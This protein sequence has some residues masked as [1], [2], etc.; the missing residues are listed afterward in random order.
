MSKNPEQKAS[1]ADSSNRQHAKLRV[2]DLNKC[3][4]HCCYD[5]VYMKDGEETKIRGLVESAPDF[6]SSL[7][8]DF[9]VDGFWDGEYSGRKTATRPH[10]FER[11]DIPEHFTRTRCVF[12]SADHKCMLQVLAV[13][14][15]LHKWLYKPQSCWLFPLRII[16]TEPAPPLAFDEL[17]PNCLGEDYP[18]FAKYVSCGRHRNDGIPWEQSLAEEIG[19]WREQNT[20]PADKDP[21]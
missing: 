12:C 17:D 3:E 2:C 20:E 5:G 11:P 4:A 1:K 6:F 14:R 21:Q 7:P 13:Q 18:G 16:D 9:I 15:G 19:F 10:D 8:K